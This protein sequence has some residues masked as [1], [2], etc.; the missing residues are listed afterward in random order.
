MDLHC[1]KPFIYCKKVDSACWF[2]KKQWI[3]SLALKERHLNTVLFSLK[4][5]LLHEGTN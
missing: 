2:E 4:G 3:R 1:I 5:G